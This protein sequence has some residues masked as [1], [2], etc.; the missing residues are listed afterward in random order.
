MLFRAP[1]VQI[2]RL[3]LSVLCLFVPAAM[4][5]PATADSRQSSPQQIEQVSVEQVA[6]YVAKHA[7]E[8]AEQLTLLSIE[9]AKQGNIRSPY[10]FFQ[11]GTILQNADRYQSSNQALRLALAQYTQLGELNMVSRT[12]LALGTSEHHLAKY[13]SASNY[14]HRARSIATMQGDGAFEAEIL[15]QLGIMQKEQGEIE[16]ALATLKSA[17]ALFRQQQMLHRISACLANIGD[18]YLTLSYFS[19]ARRYYEDA[20][21]MAQTLES[22]ALQ[23]DITAK[24]GAVELREGQ[25][26]RAIDLF[27]Q[28]LLLLHQD[29]DTAATSETK[30]LLGEALVKHGDTQAGLTLLNNSYGYALQTNRHPLIKQTRLA[31]ANA[32][33]AIQDFDQALKYAQNGTLHAREVS[34]IRSQMD[35]LTL[36]VNAYAAKGDFRKALDIQSVLQSIRE[37]MLQ[38]E[39]QAVIGRLQAEVEL[40]R[41]SQ[42]LQM[43]KKTK[44]MELAQAEHRHLATTL[45]W[46][47][48]LAAVLTLFLIWGR[49]KQ[50]QQNIVLRR[51]VRQATVELENKNS[52]LENAYK[53]LEQ[54]SLRDTLTGLYNRHY[55]ESQL[56]AEIKRSQFAIRQNK[57]GVKANQDLLCLLI[58]I[59]HF[60]RINDDFGHIAG[61]KVLVKFSQIL[62]EVFRQTDLIIRWGGEEFLVVCRQSSKQE[63]PELAERCRAA[64][65]ESTFDV[66]ADTPIQVTCSIGFSVLPPHHNTQFDENWQ[67]TF[68]LVDYCLYAAKLSGRN[69]WVGV[70]DSSSQRKASP[71]SLPIDKKFN[72]SQSKI[73]TSFN[74]IASITWPDE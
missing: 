30:M 11:L 15:M 64:V 53:T 42:A 72:F 2:K 45:A 9:K 8:Q 38:S 4:G 21:A 24:L 49:F 14:F 7:Y 1:V 57:E 36:Q 37:K 63:L 29:G 43:L 28:A 27:N 66:N 52:E 56:P 34:D 47:I 67:Q 6:Q 71:S 22:A 51:E 62:R 61:D 55:L 54:V 41:Q 23:G 16:Q 48:S 3:T 65:A 5:N 18:V 13:A 69:G 58:D 17:L 19:D 44:A 32:M 68:A 50:R 33:L 70:T 20:F 39:N 40:E 46:S 26:S 25:T 60:K 31:L 59:D 35:F 12:L 73:A 74:N 10:T